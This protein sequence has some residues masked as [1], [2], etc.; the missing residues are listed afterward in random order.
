M[1]IPLNCGDRDV[2]CAHINRSYSVWCGSTRRRSAFARSSA[3]RAESTGSSSTATPSLSTQ[4]TAEKSTSATARNSHA[5]TPTRQNTDES[6]S[7][8][9]TGGRSRLRAE[10]DC[11]LGYRRR[12]SSTLHASPHASQRTNATARDRMSVRAS[13][14]PHFGQ[15]SLGELSGS[16]SVAIAGTEIGASVMPLDTRAEA[17]PDASQVRGRR[18]FPRPALGLRPDHKCVSRA[19]AGIRRISVPTSLPLIHVSARRGIGGSFA[20]PFLVRVRTVAV[21]AM[22]AHALRAYVR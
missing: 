11:R 5:Y 16:V 3:S 9:A 15:R 8:A 21:C 17:R 2:L 12:R 6:P 20:P 22:N 19:T 18:D 1:G 14:A 10:V 13:V 4:S 7:V